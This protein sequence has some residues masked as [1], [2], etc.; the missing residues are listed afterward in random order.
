MA[1]KGSVSKCVSRLKAGDQRAVQ[2]LWERYFQRLVELARQKLQRGRRWAADEEDAALSAFDSFCRGAARGR[3]PQLSDRHDLWRLLVTITV[4][5]ASHLVRDEQR[6]KRGGGAVA[7]ESA[8][9]GP[10]DSSGAGSGFEKIISRDPTPQ[11]AAQVAGDYQRLLADLGDPRLQ[12]IAVWRMEGYTT[13]EIAAKLGCAR[14][15]VERKLQMIRACWSER[16]AGA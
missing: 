3:F 7:G 1:S 5:K 8:L 10:A 4:R 12:A 6:Q 16:D 15:T 2:D 14:C 13:D 9:L 11:L